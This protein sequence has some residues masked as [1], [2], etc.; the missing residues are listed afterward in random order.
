LYQQ[1]IEN[2]TFLDALADYVVYKIANRNRGALVSGKTKYNYAHDEHEEDHY[3]EQIMR[4]LHHTFGILKADLV[5][6]YFT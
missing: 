2:D 4:P 6:D 1:L 5:E 3:L